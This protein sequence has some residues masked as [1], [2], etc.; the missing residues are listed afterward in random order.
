MEKD[1]LDD[2][3][4]RKKS[5]EKNIDS[6]DSSSY[7][8]YEA[9]NKSS[10]VSFLSENSI[11][12][13]KKG[14]QQNDED[15]A[16]KK[17]NNLNISNDEYNKKDGNI[18]IFNELPKR[19]Y[20]RLDIFKQA[21]NKHHYTQGLNLEQKIINRINDN[22]P[23]KQINSE[24]LKS[25]SETY[26]INHFNSSK[27]KNNSTN[28][29]SN[30]YLQNNI[31]NLNSNNSIFYNNSLDNSNCDLFMNSQINQQP[32]IY[33]NKIYNNMF[34]NSSF[35]Y[36]FSPFNS[37]FTSTPNLYTFNNNLKSFSFNNKKELP[38]QNF[39]FLSD[40]LCIEKSKKKKK[41]SNL[42]NQLDKTNTD[43]STTIKKKKNKKKISEIV[44]IK[45]EKTSLSD[46][47]TNEYISTN[48]LSMA[49]DQEYSKYLQNK[50]S[51]DADFLH[52]TI[53][54]LFIDSLVDLCNDYFGN[55]LV[56]KIIEKCNKS[57][58]KILFNEVSNLIIDF[59]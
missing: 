32:F 29:G 50:I 23:P 1:N 14:A 55:Y 27:S 51:Y 54:P 58:F 49:K 4:K 5:A 6:P 12:N 48:F 19:N 8:R 41:A 57:E 3:S 30:Q 39:N 24:K 52:E 11:K 42:N 40:N 16:I 9:L 47:P 33:D 43:S 20:S 2:F 37:Y 46:S 28:I 13:Y 31:N 59:T 7:S 18:D 44:Q 17:L 15:E 25:Y 53:F 10:D 56:Q 21:S 45:E 35:D 26:K 38:T 34:G 22:I 36:S